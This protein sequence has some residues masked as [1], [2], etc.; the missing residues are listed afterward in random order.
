MRQIL[1]F[2]GNGKGKSSAA[3]GTAIR[4]L[5][6]ENRVLIIQFLKQ[7]EDTGEL[8]L[9]QKLDLPNLHIHQSGAGF[10]KIKGDTNPEEKHKKA[11]KKALL[12]LHH[13]LTEFKPNLVILD[14]IN[15]A[16]SLELIDPEIIIDIIESHPETS[17]ILTGRNAPPQFQEI[18]DL[19]TDMQ[20]VIHPFQK[21]IQ[22]Q[23]GIDF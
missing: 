3:F 1:I 10:Y 21:G 2:T 4:A 8:K 17:F 13:E 9:L 18:A 15:V 16:C 22:A 14:E 6:H 11:A 7:F 19:I 20:E 5:G 12:A 23:K